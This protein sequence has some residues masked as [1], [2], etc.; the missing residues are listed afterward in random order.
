[1]SSTKKEEQAP[2]RPSIHSAREK[3]QN[4]II[5]IGFIIT[6]ALIVGMV[7]YA[8]LYDKVFKNHI[9][10]AKVDHT[11]IDNDYFVNRVRLERNAYIQQYSI[12]YT[13]YQMFGDSAEYQ[14]YFLSQMQQVQSTLA[15]YESFG[16]TVLNS[17]VDDQVIA[18][19]AK[20]MGIEVSDADVDE[21]L[22]ELFNYYPSGTPT[23]EPTT[24]PWNTPTVS[25]AEQALLGYTPT[26][27]LEATEEVV[28]T[29][30]VATETEEAVEATEAVA[31]SAETA[32]VEAAEETP[33]ATATPA[34]VAA[35]ETAEPTATPYTEEL[36]QESYNEYITSLESVNVSEEYLRQY[37]YHYLLD[38]K[39]QKQVYSELPV[40]QEQVWARHILVETEDEAKDVL[41]RLDAGEDWNALAAELSL[42]TSNNT[43]GGDLGWFP[44]GYMVEPFEEAAFALEVGKVS[45]PVETDYGWH[46]IQVIGHE[47][48]ALSADDYSYA[49]QLHYQNWL[50]EAKADKTIKINDVWK[51]IVPQDPSISADMLV[52]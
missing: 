33:E 24:T 39:V 25:E 11:R 5:I 17:M 28:P 36:Y 26:P 13:Q 14:Q 16:E 46:I 2:K 34:E 43:T 1:M 37:V 10:V 45:E 21:L 9:A 18:I 42:D 4:R 15:D 3:K 29:E 8:L 27:V 51:D 38:Q 23:P 6:A 44:R 48:R 7:G 30:V 41:A 32:D 19:E 50:D 49:Q 35:E 31:E 40:V 20:K 22:M 52:N 47:E 12:L